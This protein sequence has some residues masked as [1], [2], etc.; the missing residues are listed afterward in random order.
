MILHP[1]VLQKAQR[2]MDSVIGTGRLP[3]HDDRVS[4]PYLDCVMSECLR[5]GVP[6]P[7][8]KLT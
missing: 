6:V 8:G 1:E 7:L 3:T 2:E 5:W 4:L